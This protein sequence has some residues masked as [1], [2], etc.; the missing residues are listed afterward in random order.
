MRAWGRDPVL[1]REPGGAPGAED[2]RRLLVEG[3][4]ARWSPETDD[5][6]HS[7]RRAADHLERTIRPALAS[8]A[9][10]WSPTVSPIPHASTKCTTRGDLRALVDTIH[11]AAIGVEPD[12]TLILDMD[13]AVALERGLARSS[14]R[15]PVRGIR[16]RLPDAPARGLPRAG[17][18]GGGALRGDR[19]HGRARDRRR[20][21][22]RGRS[23]AAFDPSQAPTLRAT[24]RSMSEDVLPEARP[25]R[26]RAAPARHRA[27]LRAGH[28]GGGVS[29]CAQFGPPA[30]RLAPDRGRRAWARPPFAWRAARYLIATPPARH[31]RRAFRGAAGA[32]PSMSTR[33]IPSRAACARCPIPG[34]LLLRRAWDNGA[35]ASQGAA[36]SR[37]GARPQGVLRV[38]GR[39]DASRGHRRLRRRDERLGRPTHC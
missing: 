8:G 3:D 12:L 34:L 18:G 29:R 7:R 5:P 22:R 14:G 15:G 33:T 9:G 30:S 19:R 11:A 36:D 38:L 16:A 23:D 10:M 17:A 26:R 24:S 20:P 4:P 25:P 35:Q 32:K 39:R 13:P 31:R 6:A 1:T 21:D 37:R 28:G 2:I 27:P